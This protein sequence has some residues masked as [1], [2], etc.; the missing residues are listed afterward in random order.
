MVLFGVYT[1]EFVCEAANHVA[2]YIETQPR[3][4]RGRLYHV[5][6]DLFHSTLY[7]PRPTQK[8]FLIGSICELECCRAVGPLRIQ[9]T[10]RGEQLYPDTSLYQCGEW[11]EDFMALAFEKCIFQE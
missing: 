3:A 9:L 10:L 6:G 1:V 2:I 5:T 11:A 8:I 4:D 7:D